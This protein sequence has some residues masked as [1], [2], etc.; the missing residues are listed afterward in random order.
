MLESYTV[1]LAKED[2]LIETKQ[3]IGPRIQIS[4]VTRMFMSPSLSLF[5][6]S[7][8]RMPQENSGENILPH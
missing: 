6:T 2:T 1:E 5:Q 8:Y 4:I 3:A 7:S